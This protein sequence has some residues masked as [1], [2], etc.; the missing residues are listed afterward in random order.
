M[1][2]TQIRTAFAV[3]TLVLAATA[4]GGDDEAAGDASATAEAAE[5]ADTAADDAAVA[6][7]AAAEEPAA[8]EAP[9]GGGSLAAAL[10]DNMMED[11]AAGDSPVATREEAECWANGIVDGIGED[12]LTELGVTPESVGELED[13]ALTDDEVS[14]V[15]DSL[16][17]CADVKQ[18]FA[19]SFAADFGAEAAS[20]IAEGLDEDLVKQALSASIAGDDS[21]PSAE[22]LE[23]FTQ[24]ASDC[25]IQ[26]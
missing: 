3:A 13:L 1:K 19:D 20:C 8:T 10:A 25:G 21:Q 18:A 7:T 22:F 11:S 5:A 12:R 15:V 26:G 2:T 4:C 23:A 9:P 14:T 17:D 24:L 16:F 6:T